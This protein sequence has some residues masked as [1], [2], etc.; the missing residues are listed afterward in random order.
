M[1]ALR[2][3]ISSDQL[4]LLLAFEECKG[5]SHLSELVGR[6][7]SVVSRNLQRI[8]ENHPLL[9][10]VRNRWDLTPLGRQVA[11]QTREY[12]R[13]LQS[14]LKQEDASSEARED[15]QSETAVLII[16]NAQKGLLS[17]AQGP[18]NNEQAESNI[19]SLLQ[20][21][22]SKE[23]PIIHVRHVSEN[24]DSLFYR[25]STGSEFLPELAPRGSE[26]VVEKSKA[27]AFVN[28]TL[29][30]LLEQNGYETLILTG[31]TANECID[32]TAKQ[33]CD[34]GFTTYVV[35]DATA[36]FELSGPDGKVY[37]AE[38]VHQLVLANLHALFAKVIT[39]A[40]LLRIP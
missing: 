27:S 5:L 3:P 34:L 18:R 38:R 17:P 13:L 10:K 37:K 23:M 26:I 28:S 15:Y 21:W 24:P 36:T 11:A 14:E 33:A 35:G 16:I 8:A 19:A 6:D 22:R 29:S 31:F 39:S 2:F 4:E 12:V 25:N 9:V 32:A 7:P 30:E 20:Q 40:A 1:S